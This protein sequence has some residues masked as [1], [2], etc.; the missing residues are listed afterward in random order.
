MNNNHK[1]LLELLR[2]GIG[3]SLTNN[4]QQFNWGVARQLVFEQGVSAIVLDGIDRLPESSRPPKDVLL[5]WIGEVMQSYEYRYQAYEKAI[6]TLAHFHS[7]HGYKMMLLKGYACSQ[8]WPKP[9]HRPC[10]D[11]DIWEFGHQEEV[12]ALMAQENHIE[13]DNSHHIHTVYDWQGFTVENHYDFI[14]THAHK[15]SKELETL[16]KELGTDDSYSIDVKGEKVYIPSPNMNALFLLRHSMAH[17]AAQGINLRQ[18]LDWAFFAKKHHDEI[19]WEWLLETLEKYGMK[20]LYGIF[21]AICVE[22]LGFETSIFHG[23]VQFD[24]VLKDRVLNEIL[25]PE[26][27]DALPRNIVKRVLYKYRRWRGN[28]WKQELC[29]KES[30]WE[31]FWSGVWIHLLKPGTI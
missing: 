11:I 23:G 24:P 9:E 12:D 30:R 13:I 28:A 26:Y 5:S 3:H 1:A 2:L 25:S 18:L 20:P 14:N 7:Q 19:D 31:A 8:D 21:N 22:D 4:P 29:F 15:S 10:G 6:S 17:F 27:P 16:F